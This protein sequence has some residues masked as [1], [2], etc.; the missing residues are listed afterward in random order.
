MSPAEQA[1]IHDRN[2][3]VAQVAASAHCRSLSKCPSA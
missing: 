1:D 3:I 2:G